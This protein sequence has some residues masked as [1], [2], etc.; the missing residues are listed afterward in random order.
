MKR[1]QRRAIIASKRL[2]N[3]SQCS[4]ASIQ[5]SKW[6]NLCLAYTCCA[7]YARHQP[8]TCHPKRKSFN[9]NTHQPISYKLSSLTMPLV[10]HLYFTR[11]SLV[12]Y[13][14]HIFPWNA[15]PRLE[16]CLPLWW[17]PWIQALPKQCPFLVPKERLQVEGSWWSN[18]N[19]RLWLCISSSISWQS[20]MSWVTWVT[21][22]TCVNGLRL[23]LD[24]KIAPGMRAR[25]WHRL[26]DQ[27][28]AV[29][30]D[31]KQEDF[32]PRNSS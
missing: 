31:N 3:D 14:L 24:G 26:E 13:D 7:C 16:E 6:S 28:E 2:L 27:E 20:N 12:Y 15:M 11:L 25:L 18:D 23:V 4:L 21:W 1:A 19:L 8:T 30:G 10:L 22:V 5:C 17:V 9:A 29:E 32:L